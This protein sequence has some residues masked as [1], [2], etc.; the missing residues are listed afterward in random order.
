MNQGFIGMGNSP[1]GIDIPLGLSMELTMHPTAATTFS[2][3]SAAQKHA[4][5]HYIQTA[6]TGVEAKQRI[7]NA[8][9][10]MESGQVTF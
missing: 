10:Q 7:K 5:I 6:T 3:M 2:N 9:S 4:A 1:D 8:V